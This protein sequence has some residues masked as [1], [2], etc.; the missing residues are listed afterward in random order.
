MGIV[1]TFNERTWLAW[2][3]KVRIIIITFL[4]G[5]ELTIATL[6]RSTLNTRLFVLV[7][8]LWYTISA[9]Y[10]LLLS[11]WKESKLQ[12]A[13]QVVTDLLFATALVWITGGVDTAFNFLYP[14]III[15]AAIVL[16]RFWAYVTAVLSFLL[17]GAVLK[18]SNFDIIPSYSQSKLDP[19]SLNATALINFA[20]FLAIAY[21]AGQLTAKLRKVDVQ[22]QEK[23]GALEHL[24]ALHE[25]IVNSMN[26]GLITTGLDGRIAVL[27][28]AAERLLE[29][30]PAELIGKPAESLWLDP[31]PPVSSLA[32]SA[33][34]REVRVLTPS[35]QHKTFSLTAAALT[36]ADRAVGY[37]YTF[38]DRTEI[39]RLEREV[40]MRDRMAAVGRMAAGIAHEIRNPLSSIA[41]SVHVL[42]EIAALDEE[43]RTLVDVVIRESERLN[44]IITGF[45]D[46]SREKVWEFERSDLVPLLEETL[47][48][49]QN[50]PEFAADGKGG[51]NSIRLERSFEC[52]HAYAMVDRDRLKQVFWNI[53]DNAVRAMP[54]G[55]TLTVSLRGTAQ[56]WLITFG[57]TGAGVAPQQ[58]DKIFEPFQSAFEKGTGLGLAI[59]YDI[60]QAHEGK[61]SVRSTP[62]LGTEFTLELKRVAQRP[63]RANAA[64]AVATTERKG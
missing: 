54:N 6:T 13:L 33:M 12:A 53:C 40:R 30:S 23:S 41:G 22:L 62:G 7:I 61:V 36:E 34:N 49:L 55:G 3:V 57:D 37:V 51:Q 45:L 24:Q 9:F 21:L 1:T 60:V 44:N 43:Q 46:Y 4:L 25:D 14:L 26:S 39:R 48:L 8:L 56:Y 18:L 31:P 38:E 59:V 35:G 17:F 27:N 47:I 19:N 63:E 11:I 52:Q 2:L 50:R 42:A 64:A 58:V 20:G 15:V 29:R 10:V 32:G 16:S 5:I 28:P